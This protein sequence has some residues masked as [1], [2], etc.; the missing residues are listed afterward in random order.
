MTDMSKP[1]DRRWAVIGSIL[2]LVGLIV[3]PF[4][5]KN[6]RVFQFNLVLVYAIA[7]L[8]LNILT[9]FN[10]QISLGHGAFYAVGAYTAAVL[11][12]KFGMPF[13]LTLPIAG[14]LCFSFGFLMGFPA[15]RLAG[16]YL[17][18]ATFALALA[19]PQL[20]KYKRIEGW[21]GGVQGIVLTKPDPPFSMSLFGQPLSPDRW[22][23]FVTLAVAALMFLLAWNL[24]RGRVG[25]ALVAIRDHPIAA[26]AMGIN[27]PMFKSLTFG[28]SAAYTGIAGALG[29][30]VVAF[31]SPDSY[32]VQLSIFMLVGV[33]VGGLASIPGAIFGA[34]FI[35]YVPN[36][37]DQVSK[38]AP[39]AIYGILLIGLMFLMPTGVM[40]MVYKTW[41][42]LRARFAGSAGA[43]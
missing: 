28:V 36:I 8:G 29:G 14:V 2:L 40:G 6:Y 43:Q 22:L 39:A 25:R 16:H 4:L 17:A 41:A 20:L 24:L 15:L 37:A 26:T 27:L 19:V 10:G 5:F 32:T 33:V 11:M 42:R 23:Y 34:I 13:W 7:V 9:G 1:L 21:T 30:V 18:L 35:Q 12:D 38:S 3:L 31:V